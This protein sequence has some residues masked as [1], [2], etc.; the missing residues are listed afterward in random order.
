MSTVTQHSKK[1]IKTVV[2]YGPLKGHRYD[3]KEG[4]KILHLHCGMLIPT[5]RKVNKLTKIGS[6]FMVSSSD[7]YARTQNT[8]KRSSLNDILPFNEGLVSQMMVYN[9]KLSEVDARTIVEG[10]SKDEI[11]LMTTTEAVK[12]AKVIK[13]F[14]TKVFH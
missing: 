13:Q 12:P 4:D 5:R 6:R 2:G 11:E 3:M 1:Q 14:Q 8:D 7:V 10:L 9:P